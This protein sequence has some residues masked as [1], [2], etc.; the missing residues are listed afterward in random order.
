MDETFYAALGVAEDADDEAI[1]RAYRERVKE[2]HP[3]VS[4]DPGAPGDFKRLTTARDVLVDDGERAKYDRLGHATYV[5]RNLA[6]SAWAADAAKS[7]EP[8]AT[9]DGTGT[10]STPSSPHR[11]KREGTTGSAADRRT[12]MG[13]DWSREAEPS[14]TGRDRSPD[15]DWQT[16]SEA[17]RYTP[18]GVPTETKTAGDH[19]RTVIRSLGPWLVVHAV[20]LLAAAGIAW[21]TVVRAEAIAALSI[22]AAAFGML[23]FGLA[24]FLSAL[25]VVSLVYA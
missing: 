21:L 7:G 9:T 19:V 13:T 3:D 25:H 4:D 22:P 17:Y 20:F 12:W 1:R 10:V 5:Q 11:V 24:L 18:S 8:A 6:G 2:R 16:A 14:E 15:E 23:L